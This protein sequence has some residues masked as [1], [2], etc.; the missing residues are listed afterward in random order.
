MLEDITLNEIDPG[1]VNPPAGDSYVVIDTAFDI[2]LITPAE[3]TQALSIDVSEFIVDGGI[4]NL[5]TGQVTALSGT[6]FI[7]VLTVAQAL[8]L[9]ANPPFVPANE[10]VMIVD[11]AANIETLTASDIS[12]LPSIG[13]TSITATDAPVT[14]TPGGPEQAALTSTNIPITADIN[15]ATALSLE[16]PALSSG[17]TLLVPPTENIIVVDTAANL[18]GLS[19]GQLDALTTIADTATAGGLD[20]GTSA[21]TQIA[22]GETVPVFTAAQ[23]NALGQDHIAVVAPPNDPAQND[24]TVTITGRGMTFVV[25]FDSSVASAPTAFQADVEQVFQFYA[26]TYSSPVTLYYDVG[27]GE[28]DDVAMKSGELGESD[29]THSVSES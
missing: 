9:E 11:T 26:D 5:R 22:A 29:F 2:E 23:M 6:P 19:I 17:P 16:A 4:A 18:E 3:F 25:T 28:R 15:L 24:G 10:T 7:A 21:V 20:S 1:S 13:V 27:F 8:A 12:A 14:F